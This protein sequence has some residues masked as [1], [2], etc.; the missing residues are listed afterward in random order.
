M[1]ANITIFRLVD[2]RMCGF[3]YLFFL[4]RHCERR[5]GA[6]QSFNRFFTPTKLPQTTTPRTEPISSVLPVIIIRMAGVLLNS[7]IQRFTPC[8]IFPPK[9]GGF[10]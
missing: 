7:Y 5:Y 6:W 10:R 4:S 3:V 1:C 9:T 2:L 8:G